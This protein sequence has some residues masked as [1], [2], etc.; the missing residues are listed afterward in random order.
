MAACNCPNP[1]TE[2]ESTGGIA[3]KCFMKKICTHYYGEEKL[4]KES[5]LSFLSLYGEGNIN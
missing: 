4:D 2:K 5:S 1:G 3:E